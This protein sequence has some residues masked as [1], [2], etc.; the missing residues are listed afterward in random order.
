ME[1]PQYKS[2]APQTTYSSMA[3]PQLRE[4]R[5]IR[6]NVCVRHR[7]P[8]YLPFLKLH[9]QDGNQNGACVA[10]CNATSKLF[11]FRSCYIIGIIQPSNTL[12][13]SGQ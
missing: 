1:L 3:K 11:P 5:A 9:R 10:A 8:S 4:K 12:F 7:V 13:I 2:E 6:R